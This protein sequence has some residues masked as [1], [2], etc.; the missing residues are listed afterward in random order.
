MPATPDGPLGSPV[1][2]WF[3][4]FPN[5]RIARENELACPKRGFFEV[6]FIGR[7][8]LPVRHLSAEERDRS[9]TRKLLAQAVVVLGR[10]CEP[11]PV[12]TW[13]ARTVTQ[14]E[15]DLVLDINR[16]TAEHR[17]R[18]R[19]DRCK[20]VQ[21]ELVRRRFAAP[22]AHDLRTVFRFQPPLGHRAIDHLI[23]CSAARLGPTP[24][25]ASN[26]TVVLQISRHSPPARQN[27]QAASIRSYEGLSFGAAVHSHRSEVRA[28]RSL[29]N[30]PGPT[31]LDTPVAAS[32]PCEVTAE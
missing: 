22:A 29:P 5:A 6:R 18:E 26:P 9:H 12:V 2:L 1:A 11:N 7:Q 21:H 3:R 23:G 16:Y 19:C 32:E 4:H 15:H 17:P 28:P 14:N 13:V 20:C 8:K 24:P 10:G 27:R 31:R 25:P 30:R